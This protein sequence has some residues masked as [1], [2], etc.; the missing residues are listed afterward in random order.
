MG[1]WW[2]PCIW[3]T[4]QNIRYVQTSPSLSIHTLF[5]LLPNV[6]FFVPPSVLYFQ[7][8][9]DQAA[10]SSMKSG[11]MRTYIP[12]FYA[13]SSMSHITSL[14]ACR[15]LERTCPARTK[16]PSKSTSLP[17]HVTVLIF[18]DINLCYKSIWSTHTNDCMSWFDSVLLLR[19]VSIS[20][21]YRSVIR[22]CMEELQQ[23]A[24]QDF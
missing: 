24:G 12:P 9:Q 23:V 16:N 21:N 8:L 20:K 17:V 13:N 19:F 18:S 1:T 5:S 15:Q 22:A 2:Y 4:L 7:V 3:N 6:T 14:L 11:K 10:P